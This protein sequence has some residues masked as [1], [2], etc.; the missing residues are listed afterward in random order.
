MCCC[1]DAPL[2][3]DWEG[4]EFCLKTKNGGK[5]IPLIVTEGDELQDL[6]G[7]GTF[8]AA[9]M[10]VKHFEF[11]KSISFAGKRVLELGAGTGTLGLGA[12]LLGASDVVLTDLPCQMPLLEKNI[13]KNIDSWSSIGHPVPPMRAEELNWLEF[14]ETAAK[15]LGSFDFI[16]GSELLFVDE[17]V[18]PLVKVLKLFCKI[19]PKCVVYIGYQ[20]RGL[21]QEEEFADA[22]VPHGFAYSCVPSDEQHPQYRVV[23]CEDLRI[24]RVHVKAEEGM[25][26]PWEKNIIRPDRIEF[27]NTT[28]K[29]LQ[30][31]TEG[32]GSCIWEAAYIM[33][34]YLEEK[35]SDW[36]KGVYKVLDFS[37]GT[38]LVGIAVSH[39][40]Q[41]NSEEEKCKRS[42]YISDLGKEQISLIKKNCYLNEKSKDINV[43]EI[44]WS[45]DPS[46]IP[47]HLRNENAPDL[48]LVSDCLYI[49]VRD[50]L[51]KE[52][53]ST[54][55]SVCSKNTKVL[56]ATKIRLEEEND[57]IQELS[58]H[59]EIEE[60]QQSFLNY[61]DV[62]DEDGIFNIFQDKEE[63]EI[64]FVEMRLKK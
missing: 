35:K 24:F 53:V 58:N 47:S 29:I 17:L 51:Q 59:F 14:D 2:D 50:G 46:N 55:R 12:A 54:L 10:T 52:F 27:T 64:N 62:N 28:L 23:T 61:K 11:S 13:S 41:E 9:V 36:W 25:E 33:I 5:E 40:E 30:A 32:T 48:V 38:G 26:A 15:R 60:I 63:T 18:E 7:D 45:I 20:D 21:T 16:V 19:N 34:R 43:V 6:F 8:I 22:L 3:Y 49:T 4:G 42:V 1:P 31:T 37:G 44:G 39:L 57:V 56:M